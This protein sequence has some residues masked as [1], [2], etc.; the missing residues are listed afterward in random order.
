[1]AQ[2]TCGLIK[3]WHQSEIQ[4]DMLALTVGSAKALKKLKSL[5]GSKLDIRIKL[6]HMSVIFFFSFNNILNWWYK[7]ICIYMFGR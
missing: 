2:T 4:K 1:M 6:N 5:V 3:R 7:I